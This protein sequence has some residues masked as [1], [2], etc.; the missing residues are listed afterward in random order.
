MEITETTTRSRS[1]KRNIVVFVVTNILI[2]GALVLLWT[3]LTTPVSTATHSP[4]DPSVVGDAPSPLIGK[5]APAFDL[6]LVNGNGE[7]VRLADY[8]GK[9]VIVNFWASWCD[10]CNAEAPVLQSSWLD[11]KSKGVVM[12][13]ID[14]G[15]T[16]GA[17]SKF[18]QKYGVTYTNIMDN[19]GGDTSIAYG[20]TRMPET[21]FIDRD[22]KVVAHWIG[23]LDSTG[24]QKE[25]AKL[26]VN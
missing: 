10:P 13:G 15:E 20:V 3:Q 16:A 22:G 14:G 19:V 21:F 7:N 26:Q 24:L 11:L 2:I 6:P 4:D 25:L 8:K 9:P 18:L 5:A 23:A 17:G 1:R 12:I